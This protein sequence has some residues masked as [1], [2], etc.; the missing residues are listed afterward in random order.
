[1]TGSLKTQFED[2]TDAHTS[3]AGYLTAEKIFVVFM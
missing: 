1:M 3:L 2:M